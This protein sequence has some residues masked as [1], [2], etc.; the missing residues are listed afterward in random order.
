[1]TRI[2]VEGSSRIASWGYDDEQNTLEVEFIN[3][4][5]AVY[6]YMDFPE[7]LWE[8][9]KQTPG[10][11]AGKTFDLYVKNAGFSYQRIS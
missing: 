10:G 2:P 6:E 3:P 8:T 5:G 1:M 9:I 4:P 11:S 7:A